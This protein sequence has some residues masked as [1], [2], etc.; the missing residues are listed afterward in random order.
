MYIGFHLW[1]PCIAVSL[2]KPFLFI[3]IK[4]TIKENE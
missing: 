2:Q 3:W 1:G 4:D